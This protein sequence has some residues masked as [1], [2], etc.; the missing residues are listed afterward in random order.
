MEHKPTED[1]TGKLKKD[2]TPETAFKVSTVHKINQTSSTSISST[3]GSSIEYRTPNSLRKRN[4]TFHSFPIVN[5]PTP[6]SR[7]RKIINPF[8]I[9]LAE[10]LHLPLIGRYV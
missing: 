7:F 9:G 10:R 8:E 6:P 4:G 3:A 1:S 2:L 5:T